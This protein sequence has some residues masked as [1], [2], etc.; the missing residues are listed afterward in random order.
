MNSVPEIIG[1]VAVELGLAVLFGVTAY[2]L[3]AG[4]FLIPKSEMVLPNQRG[5]IVQ[6]DRQLRVVE[7]GRC[8]VRPG[9]KLILCDARPRKLQI[10]GF[11]VLSADGAVLRLSLAG[12]HVIADPMAFLRGS[13]NAGDALYFELRRLLTIT[14]REQVGTR[15]T[16]SPEGFQELIRERANQALEPLG[17]KITT[18][19]IWNIFERGRLQPEMELPPTGLV[20]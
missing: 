3:L 15:I 5:V 2:R 7:P 11:E 9:Q 8:W 10:E 1:G 6:G 16:A 17:L 18:L 12:E 4:R 20:H 19:Q 14:A 13:S